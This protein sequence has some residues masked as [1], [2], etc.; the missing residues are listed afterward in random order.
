MYVLLFR[1]P[2]N[3]TIVAESD[4]FHRRLTDETNSTLQIS[5]SNCTKRSSWPLEL[6][7]AMSLKN[8][9]ENPPTVVM[10]GNLRSVTAAVVLVWRGGKCQTDG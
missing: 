5:E 7:A 4:P 6:V 9:T 8:Q 1:Q 2:K 3:L 10:R